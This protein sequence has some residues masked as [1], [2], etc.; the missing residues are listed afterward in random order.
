MKMKLLDVILTKVNFSVN[1]EFKQDVAHKEMEITPEIAINHEYKATEKQLVVLL[2]VRQLLGDIPYY[3]EIESIGVFQ[4]N[5]IPEEKLLKQFSIMNC[6]AI[7][8]PYVR[9]T[10][11]DL[12]RRSGFPPLHLNPINF[13]QLAKDKE[14]QQAKSQTQPKK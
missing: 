1:R 7:I 13:V 3:F 9:E 5:D 11:A 14:S 10:V 8:F 12:T 6:P 4:F 2:G